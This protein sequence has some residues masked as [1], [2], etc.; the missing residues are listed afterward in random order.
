MRAIDFAFTPAESPVKAG[1]TVTWTNDGAT[2]HTVKGK[3]FF[4]KAINPGR[5]YEFKFSK[6]GSY[7]YLCTLHPDSMKGTVVVEG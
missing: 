5:S 6:P 2:I 7:D 4:S 1:D 3:G